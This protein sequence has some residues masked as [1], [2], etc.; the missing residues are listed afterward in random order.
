MQPASR[1]LWLAR[2][3]PL[4]T[5]AGFFD[6]F[7]DGF[8]TQRSRLASSATSFRSTDASRLPHA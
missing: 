1:N 5:P 7:F 6:A 8:R 4:T 2:E 3:A